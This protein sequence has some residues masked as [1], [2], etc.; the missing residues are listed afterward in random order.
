MSDAISIRYA[1]DAD[2]DQ[3]FKIEQQAGN[4]AHWERATYAA[5]VSAAVNAQPK[6][7]LLVG[8]RA[9]E[10]V[11]F[12][13]TR[14]VSITGYAT[15]CELE[16]IAVAPWAARTGIGTALLQSVCD[17]ARSEGAVELRAEVR[18]SNTAA[19]ELYEAAGFEQ[20]AIR[21]KYYRRPDEDARMLRLHL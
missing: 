20:T 12:A 2:L 6:R 11:G 3:V 4:A 21:T 5:I 9:G 18:E 10:I 7:A 8:E 14:A 1:T 16:N 15:D 19:Q 13:V 17:W